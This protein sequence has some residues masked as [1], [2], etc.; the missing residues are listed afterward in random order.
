MKEKTK[1]YNFVIE[2]DENIEVGEFYKE[3]KRLQFSGYF[4]DVKGLHGLDEI[5]ERKI[6]NIENPKLSVASD[7][8]LKFIQEK[9]EHEELIRIRSQ[10]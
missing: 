4:R 9:Q 10:L 6:H 3:F 8:D 2:L 7:E 5:L 1:R